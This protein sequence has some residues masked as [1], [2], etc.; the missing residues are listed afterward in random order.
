MTRRLAIF[1]GLAFILEAALYSAIT[2]LLP[3]YV[4][5]HGM[6]KTAAGILAGAYA[7]GVVPGSVLG[8]WLV[9]KVGTRAAVLTGFGALAASSAVFGFAG[10]VPVLDVSRF[11]QGMGAGLLWAAVLTWIIG[12][13]GADRRGQAIGSAVGASIFGTLIGPLIGTTAAAVG[14]EATFVTVAAV[15]LVLG[16]GVLSHATPA[17]P[18]LGTTGL[19]KVLAAPVMRLAMTVNVLAGMFFG[20]IYL[21]VP[22]HLDDLGVGASGVGAVFL[23]TA[24]AA[25]LTSP[26]VGRSTDR[27]GPGAPLITGLLAL[28]LGVVLLPVPREPVVVAALTVALGGSAAVA[29]AVPAMTMLN[30][31]AERA[32]LAQGMAAALV[33]LTFASGELIGAPLAAVLA[34]AASNFLPFSLLAAFGLAAAWRARAIAATAVRAGG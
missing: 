25:V 23:L 11:G 26:V 15:A 30:N 10:T 13:V 3:A 14:T 18:V 20:A 21:L 19:R 29:V 2:P 33:Y 27:I 24:G 9:A 32:G 31:L 17:P 7:A 8:G 28:S 4:E 22:L 12:S 16:G 1:A 34:D 5:E 6:S